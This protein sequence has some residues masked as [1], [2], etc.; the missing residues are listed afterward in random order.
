MRWPCPATGVPVG[1]GAHSTTVIVPLATTDATVS[2]PSSPATVGTMDRAMRAAG[3]ERPAASPTVSNA[4]PSVNVFA[5]ER[6][7]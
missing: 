6:R 7:R 5:A 1:P 2:T 4:G 3:T